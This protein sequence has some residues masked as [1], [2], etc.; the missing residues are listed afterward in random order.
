MSERL[1][2]ASAECVVAYGKG[3]NALD[4]NVGMAAQ[5]H[6]HTKRQGCVPQH[7]RLYVTKSSN[8]AWATLGGKGRLGRQR[9]G[10]CLLALTLAPPGPH[11]DWLSVTRP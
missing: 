1:D 8:K 3:T 10:T 2:L 5:L 11:L 4:Q 7:G 6:K 9:A